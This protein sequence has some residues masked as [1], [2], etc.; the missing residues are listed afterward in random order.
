MVV[1]FIY[2]Y[3]YYSVVLA[4][5]DTRVE[6]SNWSVHTIPENS[7]ILSEVYD[8]GIVP[9]NRYFQHITL[10]NFYDLDVLP[11]RENDL[12]SLLNNTDYIILPSQRV[13]SVRLSHSSLYPKGNQFYKKLDDGTLGF[14]KIYETPCD[15]YCNILYLGNS[16]G[17]YEQTANVFD[18]PTLR[19]YEKQHYYKVH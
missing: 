4:K 11:E 19:I 15:F 18:R 6:A 1:S 5:P 7:K 2:S 8:L 10:F 14:K 9:F 16:L 13:S 12:S 3:S 17:S